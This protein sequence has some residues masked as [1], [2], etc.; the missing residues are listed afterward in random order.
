MA[1]ETTAE[2]PGKDAV[3]M[4]DTVITAVT[5]FRNEGF[6]PDSR[7][8]PLY[9][10]TSKLQFFHAALP[11][12]NHAGLFGLT[13]LTCLGFA[14]FFE[15]PLHFWRRGFRSPGHLHQSPAAG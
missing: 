14:N 13:M 3:R 6:E 2:I 1:A 15:R 9:L 7:L 10:A 5:A 4:I 11:D 8:W 12:L